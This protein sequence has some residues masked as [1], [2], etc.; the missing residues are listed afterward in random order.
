MFNIL[1]ENVLFS[2]AP[3]VSLMIKNPPVN[4]GD[5]GDMSLIPGWGRSPAGGCGDSVGVSTTQ[6]WSQ[7]RETSLHLFLAR[8]VHHVKQKRD[9]ACFYLE[10]KHGLK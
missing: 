1:K 10:V 4:A 5:P 2:W 8:D 9:F 6:R 3:Q 7:Q